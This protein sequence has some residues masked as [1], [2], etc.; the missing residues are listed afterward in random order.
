MNPAEGP[1]S[2]F[3]WVKGGGPGQ[4]VI[5]QSG[6]ADWLMAALPGGG[7]RTGLSLAGVPALT[8]EVV[9]TD[10]QWHRIGLVWDGT[11]RSLYADNTLVAQ[12]SVTGLPGSGAGPFIG[13]GNRR[14]A[15][16]LLVRP[17]RRCPHLQPGGEAVDLWWILE[18]KDYPRLSWELFEGASTNGTEN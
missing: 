18:G 3:A 13:V 12:D 2:V 14:I 5:S 1:F 7:L 16:H 17:D 4:V 10:G 6:K 15:A 9:I 11:N 8:A